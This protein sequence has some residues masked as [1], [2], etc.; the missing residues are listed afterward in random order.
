[1]NMLLEV[2]DLHAGY[3]SV[4]VLH[5][6]ALELRAGEV[7]ALLGANGAG[8]TT[9]LRALSGEIPVRSGS[10]RW[11]GET[12][13]SPLHRRARNGLGIVGE[14]RSILRQLSV[15]ENFRVAGVDVANG[16][17]LFPELEVRLRLRAGLLS[18]G[19]QQMLALALAVGREPDLL[20][21]D[22]LSLG[23]APLVVDRLSRAVRAAADRGVGVLVVE[24]HVRRILA[25]A[26]S[27]YVLRR[28][29]VELHGTASDLAARVEEI[30]A[31]YFATV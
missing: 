4:D 28:G 23:L 25:V 9:T 3:G 29:V 12:T 19:E 1:M 16:L 7:V 10:I 22:E 5:G 31:S 14:D 21:V 27:G 15:R 20:L 11:N 26:D 2:E 13:T 8:K 17:E 24:Q 18:G 6:I 30:E